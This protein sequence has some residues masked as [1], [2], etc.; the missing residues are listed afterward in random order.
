MTR[1]VR[2]RTSRVAKVWR[3]TW[4]VM[5]SSSRPAAVCFLKRVRGPAGPPISRSLNSSQEFTSEKVVL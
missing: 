5:S 3:R 4:A 1:S 2:P